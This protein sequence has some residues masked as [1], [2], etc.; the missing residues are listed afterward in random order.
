MT[1]EQTMSDDQ[2]IDP[3]KELNK[4]KN[5]VGKVLEQGISTVQSTV[6]SA[7][8]SASSVV[9]IRVD[10]YEY[11]DNV[12]IKTNAIDGL[13]PDSIEVSMEGDILT[14]HVETKAEAAP[15]TASFILQER[16]FGILERE[17][18]I[19]IPVQSEKAKAKLS[20]TGVLTITLPID[21]EKLREYTI[22]EEDDDD[23]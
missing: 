4:L 6:Q 14:I 21:K 3:M 15:E 8:Q 22:P 13:I 12:V 1:Q 16:K 9:A 7:V 5:T 2:R 10:A 20:K 19:P 17:V 11:Q 18:V 23:Y